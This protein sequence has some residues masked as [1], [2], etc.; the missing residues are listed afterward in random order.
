MG[1]RVALVSMSGTG[2]HETRRHSGL[3][4]TQ[5]KA[6]IAELSLRY[7]M[8][9][10]TNRSSSCIEFKDILKGATIM[11]WHNHEGISLYPYRKMLEW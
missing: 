4:T 6:W 9:S 11:F 7:S 3:Q 10:R 1:C 5:L 2:N 8:L